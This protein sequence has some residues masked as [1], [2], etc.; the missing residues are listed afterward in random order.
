MS[1]EAVLEREPAFLIL[2]DC[3]EGGW[4]KSWSYLQ[5]TPATAG[6]DGSTINRGAAC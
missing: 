5:T 3:D 1:W 4:G 6:L 2:V